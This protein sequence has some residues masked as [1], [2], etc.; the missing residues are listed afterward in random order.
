MEY[1]GQ[2]RDDIALFRRAAES[3]I[4]GLKLLH[5]A[6]FT[7]DPGQQASLWKLRKG[8]IPSV[9]ARRPPATTLL[10]EDVVFPTASLAEGITHLQHLFAEHGYTEGVVFGHA[11]DGNLHF[12]LSQSFNT[13]AEVSGFAGF[14]AGPRPPGQRQV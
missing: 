7:E 9:G 8:I 12:L 2:T 13:E 11:K 14:M 5:D 4:P 6:E 10:C 3:L 1:Q